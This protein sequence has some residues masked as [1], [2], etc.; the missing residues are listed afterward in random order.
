M[1]TQ[2]ITTNRFISSSSF[3]IVASIRSLFLTQYKLKHTA[4][5]TTTTTKCWPR[6][7]R[8]DDKRHPVHV[9]AVSLDFFFDVFGQFIKVSN[10]VSRF[11]ALFKGSFIEKITFCL[12][13]GTRTNSLLTSATI[14]P[15][16]CLSGESSYPRIDHFLFGR[17]EIRCILR[18]SIWTTGRQNCL[19]F[20][21]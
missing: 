14:L 5:T 18:Y 7:W 6:I 19:G 13:A 15:N 20:W 16:H 11:D 4:T 17:M 10:I 21:T 2:C 1:G 3:R 9:S 8:G 12:R